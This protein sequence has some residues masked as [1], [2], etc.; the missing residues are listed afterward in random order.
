MFEGLP[1]PFAKEHKGMLAHCKE[2]ME[3]N[4]GHMAINPS[5]TKLITVLRTAVENG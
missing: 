4:N 2:M 5:H 1:V 3:Y